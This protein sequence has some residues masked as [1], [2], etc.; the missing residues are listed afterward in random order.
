M[1]RQGP[2]ARPS[3][4]HPGASH[5]PRAGAGATS[6][7]GAGRG[8]RWLP[9]RSP[10]A[11]QPEPRPAP[12]CPHACTRSQACFT[13]R[14]RIHTWM[15]R[16]CAHTCAHARVRSR[17]QP[18]PCRTG[19]SPCAHVP[20]G[21]PG[22]LSLSL[23]KGPERARASQGGSKHLPARFL[24]SF[25]VR[26]GP[27]PH[28]GVTRRPQPDSRVQPLC[29]LLP[30]RRRGL[31]LRPWGV[32]AHPETHRHSGRTSSPGCHRPGAEA[33]L[34][35]HWPAWAAGSPRRLLRGESWLHTEV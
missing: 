9:L 6:C 25:T 19:S 13:R 2:T 16:E 30:P 34:K 31:R 7:P 5:G 24:V 20:T 29:P 10:Q 27:V 26:V 4:K 21:G 35:R 22:T 18:V 11:P 1:E 3:G 33:G 8:R 28:L 17:A 15:R 14:T 12:P 23:S 32:Q